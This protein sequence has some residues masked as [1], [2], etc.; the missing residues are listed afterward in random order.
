MAE[1]KVAM[2]PLGN[3][4]RF[5]GTLELAGYDASINRVRV[6]A[7]VD[8]VDR[9]LPHLKPPTEVIHTAWAGLSFLYSDRIAID[10]Q[11]EPI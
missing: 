3:H 8:A 2:T 5:A 9:Y 4:L 10:W 6:Q 7:I 1:S 11:N